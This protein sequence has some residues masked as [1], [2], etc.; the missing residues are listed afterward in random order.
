MIQSQYQENEV[1]PHVQV[2]IVLKNAIDLNV[3]RITFDAN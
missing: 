2:F 3:V 1:D